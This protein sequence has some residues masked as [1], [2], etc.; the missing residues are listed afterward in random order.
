MMFPVRF[1]DETGRRENSDL[2]RI[3]PCM[4]DA[5]HVK[6]PGDMHVV[7]PPEPH[8]VHAHFRQRVYAVET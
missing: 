4:E 7:G 8:T 3:L 6:F 1:T 2:Q 5:S